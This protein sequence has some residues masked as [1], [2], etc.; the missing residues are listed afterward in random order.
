MGLI[1]LINSRIIDGTGKDPIENGTVV[2]EGD[3][4]KAVSDTA[5]G[6]LPGGAEKI[7]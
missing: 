1:T 4:I 7:D 3:R 2:I 6:P 5:P